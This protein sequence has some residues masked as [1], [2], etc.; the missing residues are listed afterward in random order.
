M[1]AFVGRPIKDQAIGIVWKSQFMNCN[2]CRWKEKCMKANEN[3]K[4]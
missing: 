4:K 1:S 2:G 3:R